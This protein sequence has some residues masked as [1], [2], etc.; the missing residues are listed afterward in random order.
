MNIR[1]L[2]AGLFRPAA[3]IAA[4]LLVTANTPVAALEDTVSAPASATESMTYATADDGA[5]VR[6]EHWI[7]PG[8]ELDLDVASPALEA[9][10]NVRLLLPEGWSAASK[11]RWP[12]LYLLHGCCEADGYSVW[13]R[14]TDVEQLVAEIDVIVVM[15]SAGWAGFYSNWRN[16]GAGGAPRWEDFHLTELPQIVERDYRGGPRRAV[17]GLSMGGFGAL[18]YAARHPGMFVAA[19]SFSGV[20]HTLMDRRG[21]ALTSGL[22]LSGGSDPTALWGDPLL[23]RGTWAAHNP[24]DLVSGL[25]DLP[26]Y[27][28]SGNGRPGPLDRTGTL[29][30]PLEAPIGDMNRLL[31]DRLRADG[32]EITSH[33]YGPGTHTWPYWQR[34][35]RRALPLLT[36]ALGA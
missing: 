32:A 13:T 24:F 33:L 31:A 18:S 12:V 2:A 8:R 27:V 10:A 28:S 4:V 14:M 11:R 19:A 15:P 1:T 20:V 5:R 7:R 3:G 23:E 16:H 30:D 36:K 21:P 26:I 22:V 29:F 35:L 34:E 6:A 25:R 9:E 17:A